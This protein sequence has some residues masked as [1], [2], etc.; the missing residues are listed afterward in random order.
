MC[1]DACQLTLMSA[2]GSKREC[3]RER[4]RE[5]GRVRGWHWVEVTRTRARGRERR[6]RS[7]QPPASV[8]PASEVYSARALPSSLARATISL[9]LSQPPSVCFGLFF[10]FFVCLVFEGES[11]TVSK[12]VLFGE[13]GER[14]FG[15][16]RGCV[17]GVGCGSRGL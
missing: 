8:R 3:T 13:R 7:M 17:G 1:F 5:S 11:I 10:R 16:V 9:S 14:C 2:P 15:W 12:I 4:G 6:R